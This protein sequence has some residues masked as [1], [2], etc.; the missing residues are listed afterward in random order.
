MGWAVPMVIV[1]TILLFLSLQ[2][3]HLGLGRP[4]SKVC[5]EVEKGAE[6][7]DTVK[8]VVLQKYDELG[9][10]NVHEWQVLFWFLVM[11]VLLFTRSPG[12]M[13]GWGDFL[14]AV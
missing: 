6:A 1:D 11:V 7:A 10:M 3:T 9:P 12:F 13:P 4:R 5:E 2:F 14:N 8:A